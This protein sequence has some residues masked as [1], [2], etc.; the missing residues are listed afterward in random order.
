MSISQRL[1]LGFAGL[2]VLFALAVGITCVGISTVRNDAELL[3]YLDGPRSRKATEIT[4]QINESL[5]E[6]RAWMLSAQP[7]SKRARAAIWVSIASSARDLDALMAKDAPAEMLADWQMA[8]AQL[9]PLQQAEEEVERIANSPEEQPAITILNQEAMP[10]FNIIGAQLSAM[11]DEEAHLEATVDRKELLRQM[12]EFRGPLGLAGANL[13]GFLSTGDQAIKATFKLMSDRSR[14]GHDYLAA[15]RGLMTAT[16]SAAMDKVE[17]AWAKYLPLSAKLIAIRET[18]RWNVRDT[19]MA[20]T[21]LPRA[22]RIREAL[23]GAVSGEQGGVVGLASNQLTSRSNDLDAR[24]DRLR[25]LAVGLLIAGLAMAGVLGTVTTRAIVRPL[26]AMTG[27]MRQLAAGDFATAIPGVGRKD[28]IGDMAAAV[29]AFHRDGIEKQRLEAENAARLIE[30]ERQQIAM[31]R[32]TQDFGISVSDVLVLLGG[33]AAAMR[34]AALGMAQSVD[35][36]RGKSASTVAGAEESARNLSSVAAATERMTASVDEIANQVAHA[37]ATAREAVGRAEVTGRTVQGLS[38]AASQIGDIVQIIT[39]I[40]GQTNLLALNATIEAARAGE[41]GRGFAVVASE[42]KLLAGQ[43][44]AAIEQIGAQVTAIQSATGQATGAM[45]GVGD[46]IIHMDEVTSSIAV[47][48]KQQSAATR[49][50]AGSVQAVSSLN[51]GAAEAMR[52]VSDIAEHASGSSQVVLTAADDVA[53]VSETLQQ[54]VGD[55]LA[56]V[57]SGSRTANA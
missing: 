25:Q 23:L 39:A 41:A 43:T 52:E 2:L 26:R 53:R 1:V 40:A 54:R 22:S 7:A 17:D 14:A 15:H 20:A 57:R 24:L 36:T 3:V 11:L 18:D 34:D 9:A 5:S 28:D 46:S 37:A 32:S 6:L 56:V 51:E 12:A 45:R 49:E 30:R 19:V 38:D 31:E 4:G 55:F 47:A 48:V 29:Q 16:Q 42:V 27:A 10:L 8:R 33:S 35:R 50:I 21:V 13:R 44:A